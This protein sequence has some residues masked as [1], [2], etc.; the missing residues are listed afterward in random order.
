MKRMK[1]ILS[2]LL[3][4]C[5]LPVASPMAL[6]EDENIVL[7]YFAEFKEGA[8]PGEISQYIFDGCDYSFEPYPSAENPS[9]CFK[10]KAGGYQGYLDIEIN[11]AEKVV[12]ES[13]LMFTGKQASV[14]RIFTITG[15][16]GTNVLGTRNKNGTF[17]LTD[18]SN[19][20]GI[21]K[22]KFIDLVYIVDCS[23]KS[24]DVMLNGK[25]VR[26]NCAF[27][28]K[29]QT[30]VKKVRIQVSSID[31]TGDI[32]E[33]IY[34]NY[35]KVY[36]TDRYLNEE[37]YQKVTSSI[38]KFEQ[39]KN[40]SNSKATP[41]M[42]ADMMQGNILL[43]MKAPRARVG[44]DI[45][46][47]DEDNKKLTPF[48][49]NGTTMV[50]LRFLAENLG[51]TVDY[52]SSQVKIN[53]NGKEIL[54]NQGQKEFFVNGEKRELPVEP[55]TKDSRLFVPLRSISE[56]LGKKVFYDKCGYIAVGDT[57]DEFD[58]TT[59]LGRN[60]LFE[61]AYDVVLDLPTPEQVAE[62][63]KN[64]SQNSHP[65]IMLTP[66]R[67]EE[68]K[69]EIKTDPQQKY[70]YEQGIIKCENY[71]KTP[72]LIYGREDA[73]RMLG[74]CREMLRMLP[75]LSLTYLLSGNEAYKKRAVDELMNVCTFP[76]WNPHH[77]L[78]VSEMSTAVAM[79]Y[80]WLYHELSEEERVT[81]E[82][83]IKKFALDEIIRDF[84]DEPIGKNRDRSATWWKI[85]SNWLIVCPGGVSTS[86]LA[87]M[88]KYPDLAG[89][90][91][92]RSFRFIANIVKH[93]GPD[94][95]CKEGTSYWRYMLEFF[96][97]YSSA[98][99]TSTGS[100]YGLLNLPGVSTTK[101]P[102][103]INKVNDTTNTMPFT[104]F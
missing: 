7:P 57:V 41:E 2:A 20:E 18:N 88:D 48:L 91:V 67:L 60:L 61:A 30:D 63:V 51:A 40:T 29:G 76:D 36:N 50:P 5:S 55:Y 26:E 90:I 89:E 24:Y 64:Y 98:L 53:L 39:P 59:G 65:R 10:P 42:I 54:F 85:T 37:E 49:L 35:L 11:P 32:N 28:A 104:L 96:A 73:T 46:Y 78:D 102:P 13:S 95:V 23:K 52:N 6:A 101:L 66:E 94:G 43:Y 74:K 3:I 71:L 25:T 70:W 45:K 16:G 75:T 56:A 44:N 15:T 47:I 14:Q 79:A 22:D 84:N 58:M 21:V 8:I 97:Y 68:L 33:K 38:R 83:A 9:F 81:I 69:E 31:A 93:S 4:L 17:K 1:R 27:S 99:T 77:F 34:L 86:A 72:L 92:S 62:A 12:I 19:L 80:D 82:T 103:N 87:V 100:D